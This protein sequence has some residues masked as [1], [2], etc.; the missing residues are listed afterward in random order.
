MTTHVL[1]YE[2]RNGE[3]VSDEL[4]STSYPL[5]A[6]HTVLIPALCMGTIPHGIVLE[7]STWELSPSLVMLVSEPLAMISH[8]L[9]VA[10]GP[11][12]DGD[13]VT[14]AF[15]MSNEALRVRKGEVV[16]RLIKISG[17]SWEAR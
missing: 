15:N 3:A 6:M 9:I 4:G 5:K 8:N 10:Q 11:V 14:Y 17:V 12:D 7:T 1:R 2:D 16:S 13:V